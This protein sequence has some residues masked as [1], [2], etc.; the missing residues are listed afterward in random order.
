MDDRQA[1]DLRKLRG[2]SGLT[3]PSVAKNDDTSHF[4]A[5]L[6]E[7]AKSIAT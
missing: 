4:Y 6:R 7:N 3:G 5:P 1:E 2:E